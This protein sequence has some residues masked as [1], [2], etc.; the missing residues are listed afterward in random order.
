MVLHTF[1]NFNEADSISVL[2]RGTHLSAP[3]YTAIDP[4]YETGKIGENQKLQKIFRPGYFAG[5]IPGSKKT[6]ILPRTYAAADL[7]VNGTSL[8]VKDASIFIPGDAL[9]VT[10]PSARVNIASATTGW[11]VADTITVTIAGQAVT[12]TVVADDIKGSL[13]LTNQA[14]ALKVIAAI[15]ANPYLGNRVDGFSVSGS[16]TSFDVVLLAADGGSPFTLTAADTGTNGT[17]TA[18]TAAF[19]PNTAIAAISAVNGLT[20]V[21]TIAASAVS[22]PN[23]TPIGVA[24][25]IPFDSTGVP[26]GMLSPNMPIDLLYRSSDNWAL[27]DNA[28]VYKS[29]LPYWDGQ[30][31]S[32]FPK[33]TLV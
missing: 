11:A 2:A 29:R 9:S 27:Y 30:L 13:T 3:R 19:A 28:P 21:L 20:N 6:R 15:K 18:A 12:Y 8:I 32:L 4:A 10:A 25:S 14:I 33:I 1:Y 22:I 23:G 31:A 17:V 16:G 26:L 24:S 5:S 7:A